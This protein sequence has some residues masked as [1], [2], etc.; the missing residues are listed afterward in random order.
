MAIDIR[1]FN[2]FVLKKNINNLGSGNA[3]YLPVFPGLPNNPTDY[4]LFPTSGSNPGGRTEP[5]V[6]TANVRNWA[7]E[8][9]R[10]RGG[11]NETEVGYGVRAYLREETSEQKIRTNAIIYSGIYNSNTG[12]NRTNEFPIGEEITK[13][14]DPG[15]GSIQKLHAI[16][17]NMAIFQE[18]KV[19][20]ALIDK[21]AI[22]SAEGVGT[23]VSSTKL[24]IGQITPYVGEYGI[25]K[26]PESFAY[27]GYRRYFTDKNRNAV[28][29]LSNDGLTEIS[30]YGMKDF[31]R[32]KLSEI[33]DEF[34]LDSFTSTITASATSPLPYIRITT[35]LNK[36]EKGIEV[37]IPQTTGNDVSATVL[38]W[39]GSISSSF[40]LV[41][42]D[43]SP[44]SPDLAQE[45]TFNKYI[46]DKL[47]GG[48]DNYNDQYTISLQKNNNFISETTGQEGI[49]VNYY[50][51]SFDEGSLGWTSFY[52]YKPG[53]IFS[54]KSN[55]F[56]T[57]SPQL[58][59][60]YSN[61]VNRNN[62]YGVDNSSDITFI[63]NANP[64]II[65]NFKTVNYEG[66]NGWQVSNLQSD[67]EGFDL[68]GGTQNQYTDSAKIIKSYNEG[69]Y[70]EGGIPY[71]AGFNRKENKY[72]AN[73]INNS[74]ARPGEVF[75][76]GATT[77]IKGYL[78]T[79]KVSTDA[80]TDPGGAKELFAVSTE[81]VVSSK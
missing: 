17:T 41:Y 8:E 25:S 31:F 62:F 73:L 7:V 46:K 75:F 30:Q 67:T 22:Y 29:R 77:G 74:A 12:I 65:K 43:T 61:N 18:D 57:T 26:S 15:N 71:R 60:H 70:T 16:D 55:F 38:G 2:S 44:V 49:S 76:G 33:N 53:F 19:S 66:S 64:S 24:V 35:N 56:T 54:L 50:T 39:F 81:F 47:V 9:S 4:P 72:F 48:F 42:L 68:Q 13:A 23:P 27:F 14:V 78:A 5:N 52:D 10:I 20:R 6:T 63:F 28:M 59:K 34:Y 45:V 3:A 80:T 36:I 69:L 51:T 58:Y 37:L 11:F 1:F 79:V 32:D 21:D 40:L